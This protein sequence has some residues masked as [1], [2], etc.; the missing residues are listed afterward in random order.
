[1]TSVTE[2]V[3]PRGAHA[4]PDHSGGRWWQVMLCLLGV[5]TLLITSH[6]VARM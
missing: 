1:M 4:E 6:V 2:G 5:L 3:L